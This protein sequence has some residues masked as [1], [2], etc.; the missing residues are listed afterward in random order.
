MV[1]ADCGVGEPIATPPLRLLLCTYRQTGDGTI[2]EKLKHDAGLSDLV[3]KGTSPL[4]VGQCEGI[5]RCACGRY[6]SNT[7]AR[8]HLSVLENVDPVRYPHSGEIFEL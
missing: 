2:I 5:G 6:L 8:S 3:S 4:M 7:K 1:T